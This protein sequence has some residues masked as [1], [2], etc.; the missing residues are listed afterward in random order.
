MEVQELDIPGAYLIGCQRFSD[1]RGYF[2]ELYRDERYS[3]FKQCKQISYSCSS[4]NVVRGI[5]CSPY[6][7]LITCVKG[8]VVY[9]CVDLRLDSPTF[10]KW[11]SV[12]LYNNRQI[13]VPAYCGSS[14]F[15]V[16]NLVENFF[17]LKFKNLS[18]PPRYS[19]KAAKK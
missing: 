13:Y 18:N 16:S 19:A 5:H 17:F 3:M 10:K 1:E 12:E 4:A 11:I 2:Q 8:K 6:G 7:K 15:A 14:F 9:V